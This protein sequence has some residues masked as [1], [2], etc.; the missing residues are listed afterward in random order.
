ME[1]VQYYEERTERGFNVPFGMGSI[2]D[3]INELY[4]DVPG[5]IRPDIAKHVFQELNRSNQ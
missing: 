1:L 2:I 4:V 3:I 5:N